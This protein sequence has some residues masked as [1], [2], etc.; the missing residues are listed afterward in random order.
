MFDDDDNTIVVRKERGCLVNLGILAMVA[1]G[2]GCLWQGY[3]WLKA[4]RQNEENKNKETKIETI[5]KQ[6]QKTIKQ[7]LDSRFNG[8]SVDM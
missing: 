6:K 4:K 2:I 7:E 3:H 1:L 5:I 8:I